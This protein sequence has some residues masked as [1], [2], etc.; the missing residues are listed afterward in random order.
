M[1]NSILNELIFFYFKQMRKSIFYLISLMLIPGV[2]VFRL[3]D[4]LQDTYVYMQYPEVLSGMIIP[5]QAV[6]LLVSVYMYRQTS[7]QEQYRRHI[8]FPNMMWIQFQRIFALLITHTLFSILF[9]VIGLIPVIL[10][11][12]TNGI[13][14]THFYQQLM[15]HSIMF[16]LLPLLI[17]A[18]W[19]INAGLFFGKMRIGI[20]ILFMCWVLLG[21]LNTEFFDD[22]FFGQGFNELRSFFFIGPLQPE[23]V[24]YELT[25]YLSDLSLLWK[26]V[27]ILFV[28]FAVT[29][30]IISSWGIR[31][32]Q[33]V[34]MVLT[35]VVILVFCIITSPFAL[36]NGQLVFD[37]SFDM[38]TK[39]HYSKNYQFDSSQVKPMLDYDIEK[40]DIELEN[41]SQDLIRA[42]ANYVI[43]SN[44]NRI[45]LSLYHLYE[46]TDILIQDEPV[47]YQREGDFI[48]LEGVHSGESV[49]MTVEYVIHNSN[50]F[51][52]TD[53]VTYL[54]AWLNWYPM[55]QSNPNSRVGAENFDPLIERFDRMP[56]SLNYKPEQK[57]VT[58]LTMVEDTEFEGYG[59]GVTLIEGTF[60]TYQQDGKE[61]VVD[62][63]WTS[64]VSYWPEVQETISSV[65]DITEKEFGIANRIP[66]IVILVSPN[67]EKFGYLDKQH[68]LLH[69]GSTLRLDH[70]LV[71]V[72]R[73]YVPAAIWSKNKSSG[74]NQPTQ[75]AFDDALSFWMA[76]ELGL[77]SPQ[78]PDVFFMRD[79][80]TNDELSAS[81]KKIEDFMIRSHDDQ[82]VYLKQWY[83]DLEKSVEM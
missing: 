44:T 73:A 54:P 27:V 78:E 65:N 2:M 19:G 47:S 11:F 67:H 8:T 5:I 21:P 80:L 46:V 9:I 63:S 28:H 79:T 83:Q 15:I 42:R 30:L 13:Y 77:P 53:Q 45:A 22:F 82:L 36:K 10:Y 29:L 4:K 16:Y 35:A 31:T 58:N 26:N 20:V 24:Y 56:I 50:R 48:V 6:M 75:T 59:A 52:I 51:P 55:K 74:Q 34:R 23:V 43:H 14:T 18:V 38:E 70:D 39:N 60:V 32:S 49:T 37:R 7:E 12:W 25:G 3:L 41:G 76:V 69:V 33:K 64:P 71:E 81:K 1:S 62:Q 61:I 66:D 17:A 68:L 72:V 40:V 57:F